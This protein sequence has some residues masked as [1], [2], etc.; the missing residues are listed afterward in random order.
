[1]PRDPVHSQIASRIALIAFRKG[2]FSGAQARLKGPSRA[3]E[4]PSTGATTNPPRDLMAPT[5]HLLGTFG[6]TSHTH[7]LLYDLQAQTKVYLPRSQ[8][9]RRSGGDG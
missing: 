5:E 3:D 2:A 7:L 1:M 8:T 9:W 4:R 6:A